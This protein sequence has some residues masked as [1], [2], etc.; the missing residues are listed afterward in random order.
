[1]CICQDELQEA[2]IK[3]VSELMR[4]ERARGGWV[5]NGE[6]NC[7]MLQLHSFTSNYSILF[8]PSCFPQDLW[9]LELITLTYSE[10]SSILSL[11]HI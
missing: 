11:I 10:K 5:I 9:F 7:K 6:A 1:M 2:S 8:S 3:E 4:G